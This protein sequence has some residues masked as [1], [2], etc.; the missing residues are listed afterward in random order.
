MDI[1]ITH[2]RL[3]RTR[4]LHLRPLQLWLMLGAL[5][6]ALLLLSGT[7]YHFVFLKAV[8]EGW[9]VVSQIVGPVIGRDAVDRERYLR[10]NVEAMALQLGELQAKL[11]KIEAVGERV[12]GLAG[13]KNEELRALDE[14]GRA[15]SQA[16]PSA[17]GPGGGPFVPA[18]SGGGAARLEQLMQQI[19]LEADRQSDLLVLAESRLLSRRLEQMLVPSIRPVEVAIG[20]GFGFRIDPFNGRTALHTG[21]DFAAPVGTPIRAAAGGRVIEAQH[22]GAYGLALKIDHGQGLVTRYAHSSEIL[23]RPGELVRRGQTV[24]RVGSTGRS[25]GPH[26]HFEVLLEGVQQDPARFLALGERLDADLPPRPGEA[27][28]GPGSF[29]KGR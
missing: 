18:P 3:A 22:D 2:G 4:S 25:T 10:E 11:L 21:L 24:A 16:S 29:A 23:V 14:A 9:P 13:L 19:D 15:A 1:L 7:V 6:L 27:L 12:S 20:S 17:S 26:L 5:L 8:R 28:P